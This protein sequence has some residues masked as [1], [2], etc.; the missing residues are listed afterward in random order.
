MPFRNRHEAG[1]RLAQRLSHLKGD[2]V[3]VLGLPRGGV[4]VA[5][6]VARALDAPLDVTMV[7]KLGVPFQPELAM[8]A[9]GEDGVRVLNPDIVR[10]AQVGEGAIQAVEVDERR[11]LERRIREYRRGRERERIEG[12]TAIV[13]DD[14]IA[15]GATA[16]AACEIVRGLG[17]KRVVMA[18]PVAPPSAVD[19]LRGTADEV[20]CVESPPHF[21][22]IGQ[23]YD[24]F[25]QTS[26]QEVTR[27][28]D[29]AAHQTA[30]SEVVISAGSVDL[31]GYFTSPTAGLG[32][33][34]FAHGSGSGRDSPRNQYVAEVINSS[35]MGTLLIDLLTPYEAA[36]R[37]LVF[38]VEL[39]ASRVCAAMDWLTSR[40]NTGALPV[41]LFGASTGAGAA[42]WVA[43]QR[44]VAA[45]VSRG[46]RPDLALPRLPDV[47]TPTLLIVGERDETVLTLNRE[48]RR[49]LGG[50]SNLEIVAGATH[51][52]EEPGALVRVA[53]LARNWFADHLA[54]PASDRPEPTPP[55][56]HE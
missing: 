5:F 51:L 18:V 48:A 28:L 7:R 11:E 29:D 19:A 22:A 23:W 35:G 36:D 9:I 2:D 30:M 46:G 10:T 42:L 4:P 17:A 50:S 27:L 38:D 6:V 31:P 1:G 32:T 25:T 3:V 39:L 45:V 55:D 14:G 8:G 43:S 21:Y 49:A 15:T 52:F 33:V 13:V 37:R 44:P 24:D 54:V 16:R 12:R 34:I 47:T 40:P 41:G 53:E 20:V 56:S 26:D